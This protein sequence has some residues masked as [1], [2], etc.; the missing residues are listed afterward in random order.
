[1]KKI[2]ITVLG[3][4]F[5]YL[6]LVQI[7]PLSSLHRFE[8]F[9][10]QEQSHANEKNLALE[11]KKN[12]KN[13]VKINQLQRDRFWIQ[14]EIQRKKNWVDIWVYVALFLSLSF[15]FFNFVMG[16]RKKKPY[17]NLKE[18][19]PTERYIDTFEFERLAMSGFPKKVDALR[20]FQ[21]DRLRVCDYCGGDNKGAPGATPDQ[22]QF[23][24]FYKKVP[25]GAQDLR[26]VLGT[27]WNIHPSSL[28]QCTKC[29]KQSS[30]L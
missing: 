7:L 19:I 10:L 23:C 1:M 3:V 6:G 11:N 28:L 13:E 24:T 2:V 5:L 18:M 4:C 27:V 30:R 9:V 16:Y 22:I 15:L 20:W 12:P 21:Q 29:G 8:P 17:Q 26:V 14:L 25:E